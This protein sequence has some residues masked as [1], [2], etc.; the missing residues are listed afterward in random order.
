MLD[1]HELTINPG[2]RWVL[3]LQPSFR[4]NVFILCLLVIWCLVCVCEFLCPVCVHFCMCVFVCAPVCVS[5]YE[6]RNVEI[7]Q[8]RS[9]SSFYIPCISLGIHQQ[10]FGFNKQPKGME[11]KVGQSKTTI[12]HRLLPSL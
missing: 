2:Q 10:M 4:R 3:T 9:H 8:I 11:S 7:S 12:I 5:L 6:N 1:I